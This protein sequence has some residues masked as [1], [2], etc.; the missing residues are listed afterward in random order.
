MA[1]QKHTNQEP[2][3]EQKVEQEEEIV[4]VQAEA[5]GNPAEAEVEALREEMAQAKAKADEYLDGWQRALADF[6]NYRKRIERDQAQ[7]HANTVSNIARRYLE[8]LDDLERAL[9]NPPKSTDGAKWAEGI[10]LIYRKFMGILESEGITRMNAEGQP[11]DPNFH[12]AI[13]QEDSPDHESGVI[14]EVISPGYLIND[15][16]LRPARVRVAR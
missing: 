10:E 9:K 13:S 2:Q 5:V 7:L 6:S 14:I 16:V 15:K 12:E 1:K 3:E 4:D 11:F 8:V